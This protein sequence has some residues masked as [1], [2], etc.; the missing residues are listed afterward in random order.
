M[1]DDARDV[2]F[3][4][5]PDLKSFG[6]E[7]PLSP[8]QVGGSRTAT[9]VAAP[10][11]PAAAKSEPVVQAHAAAAP[12]AAPIPVAV[13]TQVMVRLTNG[14]RIDIGT[15]P[16][17]DTAKAKARQMTRE[18][19]ESRVWPFLDDRYIRPDSIISIDL[20]PTEL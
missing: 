7:P 9:P 2:S 1:N 18:L 17:Q 5:A 19:E 13:P 4:A 20:E 16:T 8:T 6:V 14:E 15:F 10:A 12:P 3:A 11:R